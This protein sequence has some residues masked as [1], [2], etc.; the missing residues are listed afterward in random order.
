MTKS[1]AQ[2]TKK[3]AHLLEKALQDHECDAQ[4]ILDVIRKAVSDNPDICTELFPNDRFRGAIKARPGK[5]TIQAQMTKAGRKGLDTVVARR[6]ERKQTV[7]DFVKEL[8]NRSTMTWD[9]MANALNES[10]ILPA[11]G[12]K[13]SRFMLHRLIGA[14]LGDE[15]GE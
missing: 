8:P 4:M 11:R 6:D 10:G 14:E 3:L 5:D 9:E 7:L 2:P 1:H 15:R 12:G 13:W